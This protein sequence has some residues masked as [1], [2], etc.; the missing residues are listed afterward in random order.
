MT[1]RILF[2]LKSCQ[3]I[4]NTKFH[5]G[6]KYGFV[7]LK[8]LLELAPQR[9]AV[10][11]DKNAYLDETMST[12]L[13]SCGITE[14]YVSDITLYEAARK[15]NGIIYAPLFDRND[16]PDD[17][18]VI[19]TQH[20]LRVLEMP[21]DSTQKYYALEGGY[22][23]RKAKWMVK[24]FVCGC[25]K[26]NVEKMIRQR[27]LRNNID[28]IT[29][30]NHSKYSLQ[31]FFPELSRR[32]IAVFYSPSTIDESISIDGYVNSY[33]KYYLVVS[34][35]RWI[36][37]GYRTLKALDEL[38]SEHPQLDGNVVVTGLSSWSQMKINIRNKKRFVLLGYVDERML[39]ALYHYAYL[40]VYGSLNEGF[41]YPPLEAM[42]EGCPIVASA[43]ASIPE[44]CGD[45]VL[46]FNP[47]LKNEIKMRIMQMENNAERDMYIQRGFD[48]Q[49]MI[50]Q[51]QNNDLDKLC[52][53]ILQRV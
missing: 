8:R 39:K 42:R 9:I 52:H 45:A 22:L 37:N 16:V 18:S 5:G 14:Y 41:G 49:R 27:L 32:E 40:L 35:N 1:K 28:I 36:K 44:V 43:I 11:Y 3:P 31:C 26:R 33:G 2:D 50:A 21:S 4:G 29:V 20:G 23:W 7:V 53:Y 13:K 46:Y 30:S 48:R 47:F 34:A 51:K 10:F 24:G 12:M 17:I 38:F 19:Y 25:N 6:G 15:E